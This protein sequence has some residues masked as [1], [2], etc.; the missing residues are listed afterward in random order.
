MADIPRN[1]RITTLVSADEKA[2]IS[3]AAEKNGMSV[4][5]YIRFMAL[6]GVEK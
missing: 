6:K 3:A 1:E 5:T 2:Q 4:S